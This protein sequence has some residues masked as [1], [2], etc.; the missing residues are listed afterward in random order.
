M[1]LADL[2]INGSARKVLLHAPKNGF[3]YVL[4]RRTGKLLS[5][6]PYVP[7][8]NWAT[9]I[10]P[11]SGRPEVDPAAHYADAPFTAHPGQGGA[12]GWQPF[13][14]S[15]KTRLVYFPAS[16]S[17]TY[18]VGVKTYTYVDGLDNSGYVFGAMP[19][20]QG[21]NLSA[22]R[23]PATRAQAPPDAFGK[24]Y[25]LAW[26]PVAQRA[27]W[28]AEGAGGGVLATAGNLVF[29][30]RSRSGVMGELV[31]FRADTGEEIWK[32]HT[33]NAILQGPITYT[34][35]GEQYIAASSGAG[36]AGIIFGGEPAH[37][38][39]PGRIIAFKLGGTAT[40]PPDPD[41]A[42]P[43]APPTDRASPAVIAQ[44]KEQYAKL[45]GRCHGINM[46][47]SNIVPDLRRSA[48]LENKNLWKAIVIGGALENQGMVSWGKFLT[49][50]GAEAIRAYVADEARKLAAGGSKR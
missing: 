13:A 2:R 16:E 33:P 14:F 11:V 10:D 34:V 22:L 35:D 40:F 31:A 42:P 6:A 4:D 3:F 32:Y 45:C 28:R 8:I 18:F 29:Q 48:A 15:P 1:I 26:D 27:A 37:V 36:G 41:L 49:P 46:F 24:S 9:S 47:S 5:V 12:H 25:L 19:T 38:R 30:G 50:D 21:A 23:A 20:A 39:Q 7:G 17:L 43:P 44:G